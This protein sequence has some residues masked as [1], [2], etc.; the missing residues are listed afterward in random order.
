MKRE[1]RRSHRSGSV[2]EALEG[3]V[4]ASA[5]PGPVAPAFLDAMAHAGATGVGGTSTARGA[6]AAPGAKRGRSAATTL[7]LDVPTLDKMVKPLH[8]PLGQNAPFILWGA[9]SP[10]GDVL[11]DQQNGTLQAYIDQLGARGMVPSIP[12]GPGYY[13]PYEIAYG[14]ALEAA[15]LPVYVVV[16]KLDVLSSNAYQNATVFG[17]YTDPS[18]TVY[19]YPCLPLADGSIGAAWTEQQLA[20]LQQAGIHVNGVFFDDEGPPDPWPTGMYESQKDD[21]TVASYY[22]AG[23]LDSFESFFQYTYQLRSTL[24]SQIMADPV[25]QMFPGAVVGDFNAYQSS[26]AV[27]YTDIQGTQ[28][29]PRD[30]GTVDVMMPGLYSQYVMLQKEAPPAKPN[31]KWADATLFSRWLT[32]ASTALSN[33]G[34]K[35]FIP[36]VSSDV[37][38][39]WNTAGM[40][41]MMSRAAYR[42]TLRHLWLRGANDM[43]LFNGTATPTASLQMMDDSRAAY[44]GLLAYRNFLSQGTPMNVTP[45]ASSAAPIWS[46]LRLGNQALVRT[47]SPSGK[48][49]KVTIE[50]FTGVKVTLPAPAAGAGF[51]ITSTGKVRRVRM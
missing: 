14:Q 6:L 1:T 43:F 21:P 11:V 4:L 44:N 35:Q 10:A 3:R 7:K 24:E 41:F 51:L 46:G 13:P 31:Q 8:N 29:P 45:P 48:A 26:A 30:L 9:P 16:P 40:N 17:T 39:L 12:V 42:E 49:A 36:F 38:G 20:P 15:N 25:H 32:T 5:A 18:G 28:F 47:F 23:A 2:V 33:R 34:N 19:K 50:A 22:P 37:P 27:A